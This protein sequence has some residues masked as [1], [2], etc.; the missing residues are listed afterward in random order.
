M[1]RERHDGG[2]EYGRIVAAESAATEPWVQRMKA[3]TNVMSPKR[4]THV[5]RR[6][7]ES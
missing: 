3:A 1:A 5:I 7:L 2:G 6:V 4:Q